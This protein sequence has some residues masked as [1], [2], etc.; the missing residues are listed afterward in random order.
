[1]AS[2][3]IDIFNFEFWEGPPPVIPT[4][5]VVTTH[6][7][8]V[9]GVSEALL[10]T[11]G[12]TFTVQLTSHWANQLY[13]IQGHALMV[14]LIGTGGKYVKFNDINWTSMYGVIYNVDAIDL[15]DLRSHLYLAGPSYAFANGAS[16]V[17]RWTLTPQK[18]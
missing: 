16:L 14:P 13:A 6:R 17:T 3:G 12:D 4:L 9:S 18:V 7:P 1:M 11:W 2:Y 10:G 8:G 15:V 5:K